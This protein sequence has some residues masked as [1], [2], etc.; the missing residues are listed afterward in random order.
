M[1]A[2]ALLIE[3]VAC[4]QFLLSYGEKCCEVPSRGNVEV[5]KS[6]FGAVRGF[7]DIGRV[8]SSY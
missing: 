1:W 3:I 7:G 4:Y 6:N 8:E 5:C 2:Q